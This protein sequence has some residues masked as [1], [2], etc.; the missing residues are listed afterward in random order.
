MAGIFLR[1]EQL[2]GKES[3]LTEPV[4][5]VKSGIVADIALIECG[6]HAASCGIN[7][8][9]LAVDMRALGGDVDVVSMVQG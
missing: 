8:A 5:L 1:Q 6:E 3:Q 7:S 4:H 9:R 2:A